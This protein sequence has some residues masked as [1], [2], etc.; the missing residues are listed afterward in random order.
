MGAFF[1]RRDSG[2]PMYRKVLERYV[3][4]ATEEGVCQAVFLE[5]GLSHDG[6]MREPK[7]GFL[8]YMLRNYDLSSRRDIVF[9][10][11]GIN[12]DRVLE[13]TSLLHRRNPDAK[14]QSWWFIVRTTVRF[15]QT[16]LFLSVR[17]RRKRFG[18]AGV[19]FG[20]PISLR[21]YCA[22]HSIE[23]GSLPRQER[24]KHVA[25][26]AKE[27]MSCVAQV[28]PILPVPLVATVFRRSQGDALNSIEI[29]NRVLKLIR[30]LQAAGA[31]I[32]DD[33]IPREETMMRAI[34]MLKFRRM[35]N[36][37]DGWY[38]AEPAAQEL[39]DFYANSIVHWTADS[40]RKSEMA[41]PA[42]VAPAAQT[43]RDLSS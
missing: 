18:Y 42:R 26:L 14:K 19:N 11:V 30:E 34:A 41:E 21:D 29:K 10:P 23:F 38:R 6:L 22:E 36:E 5:G 15:Y 39:L 31:P 3:H 8:D 24:F 12:Y 4:M 32:R 25:V 27:L 2:D 1:V 35:V 9:V 28:N 13:D 43:V 40:P 37:R 17:E 16:S 33:E 20:R 7:L